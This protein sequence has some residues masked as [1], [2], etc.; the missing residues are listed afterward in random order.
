VVCEAYYIDVDGSRRLTGQHRYVCVCLYV[1]I[2]IF[3]MYICGM[4][5]L[6]IG[7]YMYISVYTFISIICIYM[8]CEVH[9]TEVWVK[10]INRERDAHTNEDGTGWRRPV[11]CLKLQ[12]FSAKEPLITRL[13]CWKWPIEI[14]HPMGLHRLVMAWRVASRRVFTMHVCVCVCV[15]VCVFFHDCCLDA[16]L[17]VH[18]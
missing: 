15:H 7:S 11:G 1:H 18:I 16:Y 10:L 3:N 6:F 4:W 17:R 14:R 12:S 9:H 8:V 2:Y 13:F 5:Y